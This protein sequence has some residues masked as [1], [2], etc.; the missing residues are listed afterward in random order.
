MAFKIEQGLFSL[1]FTDYHAILGVPVDADLN[2]IRKRYLQ[3]ARRLHP[4]SNSAEDE[5]NRQ[6]AAAFLSKLVNP[7]YEKLSQEK[8]YNEYCI[9]VRLKGQQALQQQETVIL[10]SPSA[11]KLANAGD[12]TNTYRSELRELVAQQYEQ[13]DQTIDLIGQISELNLVYL[14]RKEKKGETPLASP[15]T[16]PATTASRAANSQAA[17]PAATAAPP[18]RDAL[19]E[20]YLWRAQEL[21]NRKDYPKAIL[22]LREAL[23]LE[24]TSSTC[25]SRLGAIFLKTNQ[26]TMAR[27][28]FNKALELNPQDEVALEGKAKLEGSSSS[29]TATKPTAAKSNPKGKKPDTKGG[30]G[31]FGL[32]GGKKK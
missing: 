2:A 12:I 5:T 17:T 9:L 32:F 26:P 11:L 18:T 28:H 23:K 29:T 30:G 19:I 15:A 4:D 21:E 31:L 22:E 6:R 25:H 20:S 16:S 14:M 3:I 8:N 10:T 24:P 13:L 1:N 7:A 27:I